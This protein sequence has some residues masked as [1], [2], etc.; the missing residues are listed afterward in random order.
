MLR[1]APHARGGRAS[2]ARGEAGDVVPRARGR[3]DLARAGTDG[4]TDGAV[5]RR[6]LHAQPLAARGAPL[7]PRA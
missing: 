1:T 7:R 6:S 2:L 3:T 4:P 5:P